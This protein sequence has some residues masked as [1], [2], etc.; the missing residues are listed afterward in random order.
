MKYH[1]AGMLFT[2]AEFSCLL[3]DILWQKCLVNK[4]ICTS[5]MDHI[6]ENQQTHIR[7]VFRRESE[8]MAQFWNQI[9]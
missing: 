7:R 2:L 1:V 6:S 3:F 8:L 4:Y 5:D 9:A